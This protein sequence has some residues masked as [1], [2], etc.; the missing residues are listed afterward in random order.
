MEQPEYTVIKLNKT[1]Y[2]MVVN[3]SFMNNLIKVILDISSIDNDKYS[4]LTN[5]NLFNELL[6]RKATDVF[7]KY[8]GIEMASNVTYKLAINEGDSVHI[9]SIRDNVF[10][11][12]NDTNRGVVGITYG[13][14]MN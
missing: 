7:I 10:D 8:L 9:L 4:M 6:Y 2:T 3:E 5:I 11:T 13:L 1:D 14:I 12:V